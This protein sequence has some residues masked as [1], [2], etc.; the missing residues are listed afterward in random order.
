MTRLSDPSS[1][2]R[3][4]TDLIGLGGAGAAVIEL[5]ETAP[6]MPEG[7]GVVRIGVHRKGPL[8]GGG[9]DGFDILLCADETAPRP[10]VGVPAEILQATLDLLLAQIGRQPV[11][12]SVAAQVLRMSLKLDFGAALILESLAYSMLLAS[13]G[14]SAWRRAT[15]AR[16]EPDDG[17]PRVLIESDGPVL[18]IALNRVSARNAIDARLRDE[19]VEALG[20]ALQD[21]DGR[22]VALSGAGQAFSI[23]GDLD[24]FGLADDAGRAHLIRSLRSPC[25]LVHALGRRMIV[26][27]HG[28][29]IGGGIEIAA[30]ASRLV[31]RRHTFFQL[32]ELSMGLIPG[33]GGTVSVPRRIGRERACFMAISGEK[34][35]LKTALAWGLVDDV[36]H[37]P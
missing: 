19:L 21:P 12:A 3:L 4:L 2:E 17:V 15:P 18:R 29:A 7:V 34:I 6:K 35:D 14:F 36:D 26:R 32:P 27:V 5:G 28:A 9:L 31:A 22:T 30:A 13:D 1:A 23:G 20:F 16:R 25:R 11:A 37:A 8:P 24:E 33:A 10:W